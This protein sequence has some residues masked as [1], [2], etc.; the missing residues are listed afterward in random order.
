MKKL[1]LFFVA[2]L[3]ANPL[4]AQPDL[5]S[6]KRIKE[7]ILKDVR[8]IGV[9]NDKSVQVALRAAHEAVLLK[10]WAQVILA[11]NPVT[12]SLKEVVYKEQS[13][14][15][16][17]T[18]YKIFHIFVAD[19]NAA[20]KFIEK[21]NVAA[22]WMTLDPKNVFDSTVKYSFSRT[23]W[24]NISAVLPDFRQTV[25]RMTKGTFTPSAIRVKDGWHIVGLLDDRPFV[26]PAIDK[27]D[28]E[29][30]ALAERKILDSHI[31]SLLSTENKK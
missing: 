3:A 30:T 27:I 23:D 4:L 19:E 16:G 13:D 18:E 12:Q 26:M 8:D 17:K 22:D 29:L 9:E 21:M 10:A 7:I 14:L 6:D 15:L 5:Q 28:K 25:A 31:Q 24:I 1:I 11:K 2:F 20:K